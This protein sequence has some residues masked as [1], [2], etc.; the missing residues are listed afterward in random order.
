MLELRLDQFTDGPHALSFQ[1][2]QSNGERDS[3]GNLIGEV[4]IADM[5]PMALR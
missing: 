4:T 1:S 2:R 5:V 3:N